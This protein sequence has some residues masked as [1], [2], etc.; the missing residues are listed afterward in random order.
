[1]YGNTTMKPLVQLMYTNKKINNLKFFP[2]HFSNLMCPCDKETQ[3]KIKAG[4]KDQRE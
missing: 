1:M 4:E 2:Q 3:R